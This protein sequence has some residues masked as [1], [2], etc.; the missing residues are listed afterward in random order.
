MKRKALP[1]RPLSITD[2]TAAG[3]QRRFFFGARKGLARFGCVVCARGLV[4]CRLESINRRFTLQIYLGPEVVARDRT[5]KVIIIRFE[6]GN[7]PR[8]S[9]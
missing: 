7:S 8:Q 4:D 9:R 5:N 6:H 3:A 1:L 2:E